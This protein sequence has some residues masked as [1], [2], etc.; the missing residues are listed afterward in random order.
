MD[1]LDDS[2]RIATGNRAKFGPLFGV[3]SLCIRDAL[4]TDHCLCGGDGYQRKGLS[5][6]LKN[7]DKALE[8][9][10][11]EKNMGI[12]SERE[13]DMFIAGFMFGTQSH[14]RFREELRKGVLDA[15]DNAERNQDEA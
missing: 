1:I 8:E 13:R 3:R 5:V 12:I 7:V 2:V 14:I 11:S 6:I 15:I 4:A 9:F 10:V